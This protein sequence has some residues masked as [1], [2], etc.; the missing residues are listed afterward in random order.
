MSEISWMIIEAVF[1]LI[2]ISLKNSDVQK[3][4]FKKSKSFL[5]FL[6][7]FSEFSWRWHNF[8]YFLNMYFWRQNFSMKLKFKN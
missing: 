5:L 3:F 6:F 2:F 8:F 7:L 1:F 4:K